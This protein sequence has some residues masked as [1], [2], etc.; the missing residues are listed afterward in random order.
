MTSLV[1]PPG[2]DPAHNCSCGSEQALFDYVPDTCYGLSIKEACC[3]HDYMYCV[4]RSQWDKE[5]SD[6]IFLENMLHIIARNTKSSAMLWLRKKRAWTYYQCV[7]RF[8]GPSYWAG[9]EAPVREDT[10][11]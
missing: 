10:A 11:A 7:V 6:R 1:I 4:G 3:I 5:R 9:K 8:G 2:Y